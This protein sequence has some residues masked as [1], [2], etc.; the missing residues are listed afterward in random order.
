MKFETAVTFDEQLIEIEREIKIRERLYPRW[1]TD[2][3]L[4]VE[5]A[6]KQL[7]RL[8]AVRETMLALKQYRQ[9]IPQAFFCLRNVTVDV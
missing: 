9:M 3:R 2:D 5:D 4:K 7:A 8:K 6:R 1:V